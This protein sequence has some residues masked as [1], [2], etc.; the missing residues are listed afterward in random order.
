[1][2][3]ISPDYSDGN[4]TTLSIAVKGDYFVDDSAVRFNNSS[5]YVTTTFTDRY[6]LTASIARSNLPSGIITVTVYN[7]GY[8]GGTSAGKSFNMYTP[9]P[10]LT[11]YPTSTRTSIS[12]Y[13]SPTPQRTRTRTPTRTITGTILTTPSATSAFLTP[14][15]TLATPDLSTPGQATPEPGTP[16]TTLAPGEPTYTPV[17]PLPEAENPAQSLLIWRLLS[18]LRVLAGI[19]LGVG[20]LSFPAFLIFRRKTKIRTPH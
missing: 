15:A 19:I 8:G 2:T 12:Y 6:T 9:T 5:S 16:T 10:T 1:L 3:S 4:I 13:R 14:Q 17:P 11:K 20:I 7:P 18:G